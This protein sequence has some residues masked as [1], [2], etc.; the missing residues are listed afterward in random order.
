MRTLRRALEDPIE[1]KLG[2]IEAPTLV[3]RPERDHLVPAYWT[4]RVAEL[5]PDAELVVLP[6]G[7]RTRSA[8]G[9][10]RG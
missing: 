6:E 3:V 5:I 10:R 1:D 2:E 8:R 7:R 4:E 9:R